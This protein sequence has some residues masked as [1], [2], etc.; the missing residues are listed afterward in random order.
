MKWS[1]YYV[2]NSNDYVPKWL[3]YVLMYFELSFYV[4]HNDLRMYKC[5]MLS[6]NLFFFYKKKI[7]I[8]IWVDYPYIYLTMT[9]L[10]W[11]IK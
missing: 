1:R 10:C 11:K 2:I 8:C 9:F 4:H 6:H 5:I 7:Q 3:V